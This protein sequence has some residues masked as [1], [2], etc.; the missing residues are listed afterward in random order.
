MVA[1]FQFQ[2]ITI[3]LATE[4]LIENNARWAEAATRHN[5]SIWDLLSKSYIFEGVVLFE[6]FENKTP[7]RITHYMVAMKLKPI[8]NTEPYSYNPP[9]CNF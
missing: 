4:N 8:R 3:L 1:Y 5:L 7:S 6:I 2:G 9:A